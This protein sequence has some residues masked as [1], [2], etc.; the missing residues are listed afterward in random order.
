MP[1]VQIKRIYDAPARTDGLRVLVDRVWPRGITKKAAAL[2][3]W[4]KEVAPS[5]ELRKWFNHDPQRWADF[6]LRYRRELRKHAKELEGLKAQAAKRRVTLL[7][8]ARDT[9]HNQAVV[10]KE[11]LQPS[12][13]R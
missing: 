1:G 4:I 13:R 7:F 8:G 5:T 9:Q 3:F 11:A 10:L 12:S 2:D 6:R